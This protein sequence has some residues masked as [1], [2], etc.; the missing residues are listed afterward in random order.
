MSTHSIP[1]A[2]L[3][4]PLRDARWVWPMDTTQPLHNSYADFRHD[5]E[6]SSGPAGLQ[7]ATLF[8]SAD[9]SYTLWVNG[10]YLHRGPARGLQG[11]WAFDRVDLRPALTKGKNWISVRVFQPAIGTFSY[12]HERS[13]GLIAGANLGGLTIRTG[14]GWKTRLDPS[15]LRITPLLSIQMG[16]QEQVDLRQDDMAW[17]FSPEPP[18]DDAAA[19]AELD[20][21]LFSHPP[22][23]YRWHD[24]GTGSPAGFSPWHQMEERNVPNLTSDRREY[25]R[26]I[27]AA[28]LMSRQG[29]D[30]TRTF[31]AERHN[32]LFEAFSSTGTAINFPAVEAGQTHVRVL[33][34]GEPT[35]GLFGIEVEG[36][37]AGQI[38]DILFCEAFEDG[39]PTIMD[40]GGG[41]RVNM[42]VR[43]TLREGTNR[44]EATQPIGHRM[45]LLVVRGESPPMTLRPYLHET[46]Y[47][48]EPVGRFESDDALLADIHRICVR[49]QRVCML[50][51][52]V[53]TPWREQ[54][55]W[56]GDARVQ[57][58]NT[59]HL[60]NDPRLLRRGIRKIAEQRVPNGLTYG[61]A[62]TIAHNCILP[63]FSLIWIISLWDDYF[64]TGQTTMFEEVW[65][66]VQRLLGYFDGEARGDNGLLKYD[67]R[68]WLFLDW[69]N[70]HKHGNP[71]LY[72]LWFTH[73]LDKLI[74]LADAAGNDDALTQVKQRRDR[75]QALV[76]DI[77]FDADRQMYRDGLNDD[78][79]PSDSYS[80]QC[81]TL[82][83]LSGLH[84]DAHSTMLAERIEPYLRG[85]DVE[86]PLPSSYWVTYVYTA[87]RH[88]G[89]GALVPE[90]IRTHW[91]KMVPYEGTLESFNTTVGWESCT[92]AW[93]AHPIYHLAQTL[94]GIGQ[95][96]PGWASIRFSPTLTDPKVSRCDTTVPTPHG[97][98]RARWRREGKAADVE[99]HLPEG[100]FAAVELPGVSEQKKAGQHQWSVF[101][102]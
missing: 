23:V 7:D 27:A 12:R 84:P 37:A 17:I 96:T 24:T 34:M 42:A 21:N 59:F 102:E 89:L 25:K 46:I 13:A 56:W 69:T 32:T 95:T 39:R 72:N 81:Q 30:P 77:L 31:L 49:T 54:T 100:T 63:D 98:I 51:A 26:T 44:F 16:W 4:E 88:G 82:A 58:Q 3:P 50:D 14:Q 36:A 79:S 6:L 92:H 53:D 62:P 11:S 33:D 15:H 65:P 60:V 9:Q 35:L 85:R 73:A 40:P 48:L 43:L 64:Q 28:A 97:P 94:G 1:P 41:S 5:F 66:E 91:A 83:I 10:K 99:L 52:Y 29:P 78:G 90:H 55:Q 80:I 20:N 74:E 22:E 38:L 71:T 67:P 75:H 18:A 93:A 70:I 87:A 86:S 19:L 101:V 76:D 2:N 61:H 57:S 45:A 8:I 68:Y 47:P